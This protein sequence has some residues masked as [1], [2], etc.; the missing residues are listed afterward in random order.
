MFRFAIPEYLYLLLIIPILIGLQWYK[1]YH[2]RKK[3]AMIGDEN[4]VMRLMPQFSKHRQDWKFTLQLL[5]VVL[6]IFLLARPQFGS[7]IETV[8]RSGVEVIVAMDVS[9][10]MLATD[11]QPNRLEKSKQIV[12]KLIDNLADDKV[13]MIIFAGNA[14]T[15]IPITSDFVSAKLFL[16]SIT[17]SLIPTQGTAIGT[18]IDMAMSSFGPQEEGAEVSRTIV[19]I[20]D[21]E[22]HEDDAIG[23]AKEAMSKGII[24]HVVGMGSPSGAPIPEQ[25]AMSF[26]KDRNGNTVITKLNEN[27]CADIAKAGGGIYVRADNTNNA[28]RVI[29]KSID[30]MA[31]SEVESK[32]FTD[33]EEQFQILAFVMFLLL[34]IELFLSERKRKWMNKLRLFN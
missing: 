19:V 17:P 16:P 25:N 33:F 23:A 18:A 11:S 5:V 31:K 22:N 14:Y 13:G 34:L 24:V 21:G 15:Q 6:G 3:I 30:L 29:Q 26:K 12:A 28:Q 8:K 9:N 27:M 1:N 4:L 20:T 32:V 7:K 2:R 10:S